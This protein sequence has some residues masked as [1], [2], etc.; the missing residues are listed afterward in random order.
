MT[1]SP[2]AIREAAQLIPQCTL[3]LHPD[4][5]HFGAITSPRFAAD[6]HE[7]IRQHQQA[8]A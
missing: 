3:L 7:F 1:V 4:T 5:N 2:E 8:P 6:A